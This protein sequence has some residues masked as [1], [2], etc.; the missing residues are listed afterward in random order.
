[1]DS[2]EPSLLILRDDVGASYDAVAR[3]VASAVGAQQCH[4]ALYDAESSE[5]IARRPNYAAE[6]IGIP[7]YRFPVRMAPA[8]M[9]VVLT[10]EPYVSN[11]PARDPLYE[12]TVRE[13]GVHCVLTVP[14]RRGERIL[15]LL[16]AL[17]KPGGFGPEDVRTLTALAGACAVTL[18]NIRLY[19]DERERRLLSD[20]LREVSRA[21]LGTPSEDAALAAVLDQMWKVI[22][23]QAALAVIAEGGVLR[24]AASRGGEADVT[25][26]LAD[27]PDLAAALASRQIAVLPEAGGHLRL[28]KLDGVDGPA[29]VAP[30]LTREDMR[31]GL[32][33]VF[34][35]GHAPSLRDGQMA[36]A[37]AD[38]AALFLDAAAVLRRER[39]GRARAA[40]V[41]RITR[42]AASRHDPDS[43]LQAVTPELQ[44]MAGADRA[45]VYFRHPRHAITLPATWSGLSADEETL[46][47]ELRLDITDPALEPLQRGEAVVFQDPA[48]PPPEAFAPWP[49]TA[50]LLLVPFVAREQVGGVLLLTSRRWRH[51]D[52]PLVEAIVEVTRQVS[53]GV[54]NARLFTALAQMASTD[55]L[56]QL[57]N[58]RR[59]TETLRAEAIRAR[60]TSLPLSLIMVDIDHLK[61]INDTFG[62]PA[63]DAAIRH[64]ASVLSTGRRENDVVARLGGEEFAVLLPATEHAGAVQAA[65]RVRR[66]LETAGVPLVGAVTA[67][68]GVATLPDEAEAEDSLIVLADQ[69][70]YAAK[71]GGRNRVVSG[72]QPDGLRPAAREA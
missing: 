14:V 57:A 28:L 26:P 16:Y 32:I 3:S 11:D 5:I 15:G 43:L 49:N 39:Q 37:F 63:G 10:G 36:G 8:S 25:V 51:F 71:E 21:L 33:V 56:T 23:Y 45:L 58:R 54:E 13:H 7:Q 34:E 64:V 6:T 53:L 69:R 31:G 41:A 48:S 60:R 44:G 35:P 30:L 66:Q 17:N 4:L 47:R 59:F 1:V 38:H 62:H 24:V 9:R 22:R 55:E 12:P 19:A 52:G 50:S 72:S 18:E 42:T 27:V 61:R 2:V 67:S 46:V 20:S 70:L 40:A 29:L 65:E 68:M